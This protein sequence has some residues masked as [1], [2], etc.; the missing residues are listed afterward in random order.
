[1]KGL[2]CANIAA[3]LLIGWA[4]IRKLNKLIRSNT[5]MS[6]DVSRISASA[7]KIAEDVANIQ[8][9][10]QKQTDDKAA[11]QTEIDGLKATI[12]DLQGKLA[13]GQL[14]AAALADAAAKFEAA[15]SAL[16][17][18]QPDQAPVPPVVDGGEGTG[19]GTPP[20]A[21]PP[22]DGGNVASQG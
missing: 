15:D 2:L 12:A 8:R 9:W 5:V 10:Q 22:A 19:G 20:A 14:D 21:A 13:A 11:M 6:Q 4:V 18:I 1:M 7:N 16:D 17:A 3:T